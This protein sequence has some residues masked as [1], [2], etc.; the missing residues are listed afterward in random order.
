MMKKGSAGHSFCAHV[1]TLDERKTTCSVG[2]V[3]H[4]ANLGSNRKP[5][6]SS[7]GIVKTHWRMQP[8]T[9]TQPYPPSGG[10]AR[11]WTLIDSSVAL[12]I[13]LTAEL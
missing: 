12:G 9:T 8:T 5:Y 1:V 2:V 6:M 4:E 13:V 7:T 11:P 3:L 10:L